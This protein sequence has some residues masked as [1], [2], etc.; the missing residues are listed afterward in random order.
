MKGLQEALGIEAPTHM[1]GLQVFIA[2]IRN[3]PNKEQEEK[4]VEKELAKIRQKFQ[5][6]KLSGYDKKKYV[7]KLLYAYMLG[8]DID[9]GHLQAVELCSSPK[10][11]E[12]TA[13]YLAISLL[14]SDNAEIVRLVVNSVKNDMNSQNEHIACLA[15]NTVANIGGAEF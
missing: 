9:F 3:C 6:P 1:K 14:L 7:W 2:D 10:F 12:K 15:L 8:Y 5:N 4:R 13:G 11:S